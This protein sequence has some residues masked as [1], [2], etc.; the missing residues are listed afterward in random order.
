MMSLIKNIHLL[1][2]FI[3]ISGF[4]LRGIWVIQDSSR[5]QQRWVK[6]VPHINDTILLISG[7]TLAINIQQYPFVHGWLTAKII[8]LLAYIGLGM[9]T[10]RHGRSKQQRI[11][12][13]LAAILVFMY[14]VGVARTR[15][16][17]FLF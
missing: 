1:T 12:T 3:S 2:I 4:I 11:L 15:Q 17:F 8:A 9:M 6:I 13:G 5:L 14:M 10:I 7:I 16:A